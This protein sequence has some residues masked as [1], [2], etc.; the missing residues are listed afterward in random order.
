MESGRGHLGRQ[1]EFWLRCRHGSARVFFPH[2]CVSCGKEGGAI[3]S[4]CRTVINAPKGVF[5]CPGC[6]TPSVWGAACS[7]PCGS[8]SQIDGV[9]AAASYAVGPLRELLHQ[10]KY[11]G[12][13]ECGGELAEVMGDFAVRFRP[14]LAALLG[15]GS[16]IVPV[17]LHPWREAWRGFNQAAVLAEAVASSTGW[18]VRALLRRR[19]GWRRQTQL[20]S[21]SLRQRNVESAI[22]VAPGRAVPEAV[23][24]VDDVFTTGATLSACARALK[25]HGVR[26]IWGLTLLRG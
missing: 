13:L 11:S 4:R 16:A 5:K 2:Y 8:R 7:G 3:C 24:L 1:S 23:L 26:R 9:M 17:P 21:P 15:S 18:P 19:F 14:V 20:D 12:I 22:S 10:F 6:G 25:E